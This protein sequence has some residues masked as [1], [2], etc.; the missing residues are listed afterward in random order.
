MS[1]NNTRSGLNNTA[2]FVTSALPWVITGITSG[3]DVITYNL[4]KVSKNIVLMNNASTGSYLRLGFTENGINAVE[5]KYYFN[6][7]GGQSINLDVRVKTFF[8]RADSSGSL[9]FSIYAG[10]TTIDNI[11]MPTLTGSLAVQGDGW[12]GVG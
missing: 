3:T 7:D 6:V 2:E 12:E 8:V 9:D 1:L 4:P 10:L 5:D 11:M